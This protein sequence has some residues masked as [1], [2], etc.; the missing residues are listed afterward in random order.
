M[1]FVFLVASLVRFFRSWI[2]FVGLPIFIGASMA[3]KNSIF[4]HKKSHGNAFSAS[5]VFRI[6]RAFSHGVVEA[7]ERLVRF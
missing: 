7:S 1:Y 3:V 6:R 2:D 5:T 4:S